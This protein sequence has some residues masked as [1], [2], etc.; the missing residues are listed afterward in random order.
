MNLAKYTG[1]VRVT[2]EDRTAAEVAERER[3]FREQQERRREELVKADVK[4]DR[5]QLPVPRGVEL[6]G[7]PDVGGL[8]KDWAI[9]NRRT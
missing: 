6:R 1:V 7:L 8:L 9:P 4:T 3:Q 5:P 2:V